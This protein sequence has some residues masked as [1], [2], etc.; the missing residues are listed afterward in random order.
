MRALPRSQNRIYAVVY[1]FQS[2]NGFYQNLLKHHALAFQSPLQVRSSLGRNSITC[3]SLFSGLPRIDSRFMT[4]SFLGRG[5]Q[6]ESFVSD[7]CLSEITLLN[8]HVN[9]KGIT[10]FHGSTRPG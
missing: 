9:R 10:I 4:S 6:G 3:D 5:M 7:R 1:E 8:S 2:V